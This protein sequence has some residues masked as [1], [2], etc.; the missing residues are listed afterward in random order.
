[1]V[2]AR[3]YLL[4]VQEECRAVGSKVQA[5]ARRTV[6]QGLLRVDLVSLRRDRRRMLADLGE[7][8]LRLWTAGELAALPTDAEANRIRSLIRSLD[9]QIA[10]KEA[11]AAALRAARQEAAPAVPGAPQHP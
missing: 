4:R 1:M 5:T 6:R 8:V 10:A 7:W 2:D 11:E 3:R 9:E